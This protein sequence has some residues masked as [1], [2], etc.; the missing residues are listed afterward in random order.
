[1][2]IVIV[3]NK[4][5]EFL[6][7]HEIS[8][9]FL[10]WVKKECQEN[11]AEYK[12]SARPP[13]SATLN[14]EFWP[15]GDHDK[16]L[17]KDDLIE[18][19]IEPQSGL[20]WVP[21]VI[22]LLAA[23]YSYYVASNI[24]TNYQD[25]AESGQSI[26]TANARGNSVSPSGIIRE[27]AGEQHI[28][29]DLI[30]P[31]HRKY[32]DNEQFLFLNL[33]VTRGFADVADDNLYIAETPVKYYE[34][35]IEFQIKD[36]GEDI[37]GNLG[38]E[39]WF[40]S[41]EVSNLR[42]VTER[43]LIG[44]EWTLD[45]SGSQFT[46]YLL[47][48]ATAF[49]FALN[50]DFEIVGG[51]N[52][53]L[54][55]VSAIS[56]ANSEI[57]DVIVL[58]YAS[59][60][61]GRLEIL[62]QQSLTE[63]QAL[64][65][66]YEQG[67]TIRRHMFNET[68]IAS[69]NPVV[70][71]SFTE[72]RGLN[73]GVNWEGPFLAIPVNETSRYGE[74]DISFPQGLV[75]LD[76]QN[77]QIDRSVQVLI[78]WREYGT[79]SWTTVTVDTTSNTYDEIGKTITI[80]Y[81]SEITPEV[82]FRRVTK[83]SDEISISD[84]VQVD[85]VKHLLESPTSYPDVTTIQMKIRGTNALAATAENRINVR[86]ASRK[87][88]TLQEIQDAANGTPFDLGGDKNVSVLWD[89]AYAIFNTSYDLADAD[90]SLATTNLQ[91]LDISDDGLNAVAN[92]DGAIMFFTM[93]NAF[94]FRGAS[95]TGYFSS[96][97]GDHYAARILDSG[98]KIA[99][100]TEASLPFPVSFV[101]VY[102]LSAP[103]NPNTATLSSSYNL[104]STSKETRVY[105]SDTGL[106]YWYSLDD[107]ITELSMGTAYDVSTSS[108]TGNTLD[109]SSD[110]SPSALKS[111]YLGDSLSRLYVLS[112][113]EKLYSY[114]LSTPGDIT[115]ATLDS[116]SDISVDVGFNA[117]DIV[118]FGNKI[119]LLNSFSFVSEWNIPSTVN[120]R[121]S[122]SMVRFVAN[123]IYDAIG[124]DILDQVDFD[125]LEDLDS[126]LEFREDYLDAEFIDENT[127]WEACKIMARVGYCEPTLKN[128]IFN[129]IRTSEGSDF[130]NLYTPDV[131]IGDGLQIDSEYYGS[132]EPD[133]VD[134][135]YFNLETY[136]NEVYQFRLSGDLGLRPQRVTA[137][138][139]GTEEKA[140]RL[141]SRERRRLRAKPNTYT[142]TTELDALNSSYGDPIAVASDIFGGQYGQVTGLSGSVVDL[143]FEPEAISGTAFA[144][145]RNPDGSK[146][147]T[148]E[149]SLGPSSNQITLLSPSSPDFDLITDENQEPNL[150]TI[151]TADTY[152]KRAIVRR[153][154]PVGDNEVQV[155]AEEYVS[156][157]YTDDDNSPS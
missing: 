145:F 2:P 89:K 132:Q 57:A 28:Y 79:S 107:V 139:I 70:G 73:G 114:T 92:N 32:I 63:S 67:G 45:A 39:N 47:G 93:E 46:S 43:G 154:S 108:A 83:D 130:T 4:D 61:T 115:T 20:E 111:F 10:S 80:D 76:S 121:R 155:T 18:V 100:T 112:V 59:G 125:E 134:I 55:R 90:S 119:F 102:D 1:M 31:Q 138:G 148:H 7:E 35:D 21:Y 54:Y 105:F 127:L 91:G 118:I 41:R 26:Y 116:P 72:W 25:T 62:T 153:I 117:N 85:R 124:S 27:L 49:P 77:D 37:S 144:T 64:Q 8:G 84:I 104:D 151:G 88:P 42:L 141:A 68:G 140:F 103:Y 156:D 147:S 36:P 96:T 23:A 58:E 75:E 152:I 98:N 44:G 17:N 12:E 30:C 120:V 14:G 9:S 66:V 16:P 136:T 95:Y 56:G 143:D 146:A 53:G 5:G 157:I 33:A 122:R 6:E 99:V 87:L 81:G 74:F 34:G 29:P 86:G 106:T 3:R 149:I 113:D 135:E 126:L 48:A 13:Y 150:V 137:V 50:E 51:S 94:D 78:R 133:G 123:A 15:H 97:S 131:M 109:V 101:E 128:G 129:L 142:F 11:N 19:T 65:Q 69:L 110:L 60:D 52:P 82:M 71:E 38:Y 24:P 40:E 22:A